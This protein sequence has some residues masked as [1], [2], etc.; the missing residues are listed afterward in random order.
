MSNERVGINLIDAIK[1]LGDLELIDSQLSMGIFIKK[2]NE[3]VSEKIQSIES[4][5]NQKMEFYNIKSSE[6]DSKKIDIVQK[7]SEEYENISEKYQERFL[8]IQLELQNAQ[9]NQK[10]AL[11]NWK[12]MIDEKDSLLKS[13]TYKN[14]ISRKKTLEYNL[15]NTLKSDEFYKYDKLLKE[16]VD[17]VDRIVIKENACI[18]KFNNYN[19]IINECL[20]EMNICEKEAF[21]ALN[22]VSTYLSSNKLALQKGINPI[23]K[24]I[25]KLL[26]KFSGA[27][28]FQ[29][30]VINKFETDLQKIESENDNVIK[31]IENKNYEFVSTIVVMRDNINEKFKLAIS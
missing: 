20:I 26:F 2:T 12:K 4:E 11:A 7:Y 9:S 3:F 28:K 23:S 13:E 17:P 29:T 1:E 27:K 10:I 21:E 19:E 22:S 16:L 14:Y 18:E 5:L 31:E 15:E 6:L 8:N 24:F 30:E 25:N